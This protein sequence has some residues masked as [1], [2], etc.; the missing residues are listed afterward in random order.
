[1][2]SN[3]L[4]RVVCPRVPGGHTGLTVA[5]LVVAH[6][7]TAPAS[8]SQCRCVPVLSSVPVRHPASSGPS[9]AF[10]A[11]SVGRALPTAPVGGADSCLRGPAAVPSSLCPLPGYVCFNHITCRYSFISCVHLFLRASQ[12]F[13]SLAF[14][15]IVS[16]EL[17]KFKFF[18]ELSLLIFSFMTSNFGLCLRTARRRK[19]CPIQWY[20]SFLT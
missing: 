9:S 15:R 6:S 11:V 8:R 17:Q 18:Y 3:V 16:L 1:M 20:L 12:M 13:L 19:H 7:L 2:G 5:L 4:K 14:L 10:G